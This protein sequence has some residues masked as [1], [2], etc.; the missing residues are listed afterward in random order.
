MG[1]AEN[2]AS[3]PSYDLIKPVSGAIKALEKS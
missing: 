3:V 2:T 1:N